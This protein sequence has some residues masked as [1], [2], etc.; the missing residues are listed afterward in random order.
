MRPL[1]RYL[2]LFLAVTLALTAHVAAA[3]RG[4]AT[5]EQAIL[6][7]GA[8]AV[9]VYLDAEGTP[10]GPPHYC[11][12]CSL[13]LL[14]APAGFAPHARPLEAARPLLRDVTPQIRGV[15]RVVHALQARAPPHRA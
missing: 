3:A 13:H 6:C 12:E 4:H 8:G 11:P 10:T 14:D 1:R 15:V 9:V 7:T 5:G 2:A